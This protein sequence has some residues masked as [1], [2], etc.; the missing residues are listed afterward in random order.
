M[1]Y[2]EIR[3]VKDKKQ[4][5]IIHSQ[6]AQGKIIKKS[7]FIGYGDIL[8][9][10]IEKE[11]KKFEL[12]LASEKKS[13]YLTKKQS[14][15]IENIKQRYTTEMSNLKQEEL[16]KFEKSFFTELTYESNAIE[17]NTLS[18]EET[19]LVAN[20]GL[21]PEGATLREIYEVKNHSE[22]IDFIRN[23]NGDLSEDFI[24]KLHSIILK[25]ISKRFAGQYRQTNVK[26]FGSNVKLPSSHIVPQLVKNLIYWYKKNK[27]KYT[28][29]ELAILVSMKFVTI[30]PFIDGNGR[31]SRL[32]MNFLLNKKKYP[33]INIYNKKRLKYLE[34]VR[35]A[36]NEDYSEIF[37]FVI[38]ILQENMKDFNID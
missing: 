36:N 20:D 14:A 31:V 30:H 35:F 12:Q 23:F 34:A 32:V 9:G 18:L 15:L 3:K 16:T 25:N 2:H 29:F 19:S 21:A 11:K 8:M 1:V 24:L 33:W 17:G 26:I 7:K 27:S 38:K 4:N 13:R 22:A 37:P 10:D 6:R 5:Y 28:H